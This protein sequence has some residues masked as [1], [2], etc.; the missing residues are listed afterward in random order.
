[1]STNKA[2]KLGR[3][4]APNSNFGQE[5][6]RTAERR[7]LYEK[8]VVLE[9]HELSRETY[10]RG[11]S[12]DE[13][14]ALVYL[15]GVLFEDLNSGRLAPYGLLAVGTATYQYSYWSGLESFL[16]RNNG[17]DKLGYVRRQGEDLDIILCVDLPSNNI[18]TL[19]IPKIVSSVKKDLASA[20]D[21]GRL[22]FVHSV[23]K[24]QDGAIYLT[25]FELSDE[26]ETTPVRARRHKRIDYKGD[27]F[28]IKFKGCRDIHLS[29]DDL[30]IDE[31]LK[32][33]RVE[34]YEFSLLSR[35]NDMIPAIYR[36]NNNPGLFDRG[37]QQKPK[38]AWLHALAQSCMLDRMRFLDRVNEQKRKGGWWG[39]Q[40]IDG[41]MPF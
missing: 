30:N 22:T 9:T 3:E 11:I 12:L 6:M 5:F 27:N 10:L 41:E 23:D 24:R 1:M 36:I 2:L 38:N 37:D 29:F 20:A 17:Q 13:R 7:I 16:R 40:P 14:N 33:E 21:N 31:K 25:M 19:H 8:G 28:R 39:D 32:S 34:D 18:R 26:A 4:R 35:H 15:F